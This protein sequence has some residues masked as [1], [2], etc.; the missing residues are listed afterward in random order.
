MKQEKT[1]WRGGGRRGRKGGK[2]KKLC[3]WF[4]SSDQQSR[5]G[6]DH[7]RRSSIL[8]I[9]LRRL[10]WCEAIGEL[11]QSN[12]SDTTGEELSSIMSSNMELLLP[13]R[14]LWFSTEFWFGSWLFGFTSV[15]DWLRG[16]KP[17]MVCMGLSCGAST[18]IDMSRFCPFSEINC[19]AKASVFVSRL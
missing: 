9:L 3:T 18:F 5:K 12:A 7:E 17:P 6:T 14:L 10:L 16:P 13:V 1:K 11:C 15:A 19:V 4:S 8:V 2:K